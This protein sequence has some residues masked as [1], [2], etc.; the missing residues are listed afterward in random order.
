MGHHRSCC[1]HSTYLNSSGISAALP[2]LHHLLLEHHHLLAHLPTK[3][4]QGDQGPNKRQDMVSP[5]FH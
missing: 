1:P 3:G 5:G 4:K 2:L